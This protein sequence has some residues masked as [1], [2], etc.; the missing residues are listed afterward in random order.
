[1]S[2]IILVFGLAAIAAYYVGV[3]VPEQRKQHFLTP[4]PFVPPS[5]PFSIM[6]VDTHYQLD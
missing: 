5:K 3:I 6:P 2:S 1:M 4:Q